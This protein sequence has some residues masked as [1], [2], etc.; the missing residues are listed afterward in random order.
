[1]IEP[2]SVDECAEVMAR[3]ARDR[4][5]VA[6][7]GGA[8][9]LGLGNRG[10]EPDLMLST[11]HLD[12]V[13]DYAPE[14]QVIVAEAGLTLAR[15]AELTAPNAQ[16]FGVDAPHRERA[17]LGGLVAVGGFGPRRMRYGGMRELLIGLTLVRADGAISQSGSKVVKN[18]AG[19]D[20]PKV[21]CGSLG[22]LGLVARVTLRLHPAPEASQ[23]CLALDAASADIVDAVRSLRRA[24]LEP[25][26]VVALRRGAGRFELG[27]R[28][29]G[30]ER[31]VRRDV[32]RFVQKLSGLR[33]AELDRAQNDAFWRDHE[34]VRTDGDLRVR[35]AALPTQFGDVER[36]LE[37]LLGSL[38]RPRLAWYAALGLGFASGQL[39]SDTRALDALTL[40]RSGLVRLGGSLTVEVAPDA[41]RGAFDAFGPLPSAFGIMQ[42]L[43]LRFDPE[44]RLNAGRFVGGL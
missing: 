28:F 1:M 32:E 24:Q 39:T 2:A 37:P 25:S 34:A 22:T 30:F 20:L 10:P 17:T 41:V 6:F 5:R 7:V 3:A 36:S 42:E 40:A 14:D 13:V 33:H 31:G 12:R 43:K 18:V 29:E 35:V 27:V 15:L 21:V 44:R 16:C 38:E 9:A 11:R 23:T 19:F 8:T 26:S 4:S